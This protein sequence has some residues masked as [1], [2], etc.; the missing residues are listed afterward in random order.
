MGSIKGTVRKNIKEHARNLKKGTIAISLLIIAITTIVL[1]LCAIL[2]GNIM[3][4]N[5][6]IHFVNV[7]I[8]AIIISLISPLLLGFINMVMNNIK[9][10][11]IKVKD[12]YA[13]VKGHK[14]FITLYSIMVFVLAVFFGILGLIPLIGLIINFI[15]LLVV[16]PIYLLIPAV[17]LENQK[18]T[19]KEILSKTFDIVSGRRLNFYAMIISFIPWCLLADLTF[20]ILYLYVIPYLISAIILEYQYWNHEKEFEKEKTISDGVVILIFLGIAFVL[21]LVVAVNIPSSVSYFKEIIT[22]RY[23]SG[24]GNSYLSYGG[25][26]ISYNSPK[27]Y[28]LSAETDTSKTY[29]NNDNIVQYSIY[30]SNV[31]DAYEMDKEIVEEMKNSGDYKHV[32]DKEYTVKVN[33][34]EIKCYQYNKTAKETVATAYYPKDGYVVSISLSNY[35]GAEISKEDI[36]ELITVY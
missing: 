32:K 7:L 22:G 8:M 23:Y 29:V 12:L 19:N 24:E 9:G 2:F 33:G 20:G 25:T 13:L 6:D 35:S 18:L 4:Y 3:G 15:L 34:K 28:T 11:E 17:Y 26:K 36:K 16:L 5:F 14:K 21:G 10:Q 31:K 1:S 30:L 27:G